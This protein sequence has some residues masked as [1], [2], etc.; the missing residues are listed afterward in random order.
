[1]ALAQP[2]QK[3]TLQLVIDEHKWS[4]PELQQKT[5]QAMEELIH[6][7][8]DALNQSGL[9]ERNVLR[10]GI[11]S[12]IH[13]AFIE[14]IYDAIGDDNVLTSREVGP[15]FW[16]LTKDN[17]ITTCHTF[18][19]TNLPALI[20]DTMNQLMNY[21]IF[22]PMSIHPVPLRDE[23]FETQFEIFR[24][25][26][27]AEFSSRIETTITALENIIIA[28]HKARQQAD[29]EIDLELVQLTGKIKSNVLFTH[30]IGLERNETNLGNYFELSIKMQQVAAINFEKL[31]NVCVSA[32]SRPFILHINDDCF[33]IFFQI[34]T[35]I[36]VDRETL[37]L[38]IFEEIESTLTAKT[39]KSKS[40]IDSIAI[41]NKHLSPFLHNIGI[42]L[43]H[44][45]IQNYLRTRIND[46]KWSAIKM[47]MQVYIENLL[48]F[49]QTSASQLFSGLNYSLLQTRHGRDQLRDQLL[50]TFQSILKQYFLHLKN[51]P[52]NDF[53]KDIERMGKIGDKLGTPRP[54]YSY[55][56]QRM[57]FY[58]ETQY[59]D[60]Q[61]LRAFFR[62][63]FDRSC[64]AMTSVASDLVSTVS[65]VNGEL[66][67][68]RSTDN[69]A[70]MSR[71]AQFRV[72]F[73]DEINGKG[74]AKVVF[75]N[76]FNKVNQFCSEK[77]G[78]LLKIL[79]EGLGMKTDAVQTSAGN[80]AKTSSTS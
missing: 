59:T 6:Q 18:L 75:E 57:P 77:V 47:P 28:R 80:K 46:E 64:T 50:K 65:R 44:R 5:I 76:H 56:K 69:N 36:L 10:H 21:G 52:I 62:E 39:S 38:R 14:V 20:K 61:H 11:K 37:P 30:K 17:I 67:L 12:Q 41:I 54:V 58:A 4:P 19:N 8:L 48:L 45:H 27:I 16:K 32:V 43:N 42:H 26:F 51:L 73:D 60:E 23:V 2:T 31:R 25:D 15:A 63:E 70:F 22:V 34:L 40:S 7:S 35:S 66:N 24:T 55:V 3:N 72:D 29:D 53:E 71:V 68:N 9:P 74:L 79:D 1:M 13:T 78:S 33:L 49:I